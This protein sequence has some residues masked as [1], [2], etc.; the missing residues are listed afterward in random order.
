[1]VGMGSPDYRKAR[2]TTERMSRL[3]MV[4]IVMC[5]RAVRFMLGLQ[6][7][8]TGPEGGCSGRA[9]TGPATVVVIWAEF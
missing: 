3:S 5:Q 2:P 8:A 9:A 4:S 1:M 7:R 6:K